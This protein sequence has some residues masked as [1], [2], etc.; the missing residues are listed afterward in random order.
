MD[1][2]NRKGLSGRCLVR[3]VRRFGHRRNPSVVRIRVHYG[4]RALDIPS[5][6]RFCAARFRILHAGC[7]RA[8]RPE[9]RWDRARKT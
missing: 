4:P 9:S 5:R 2:A 7:Y 1:A 8:F 6:T 3:M